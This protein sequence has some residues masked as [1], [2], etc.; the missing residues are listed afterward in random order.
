MSQRDRDIEQSVR[1]ALDR[2]VVLGIDCVPTHVTMKGRL[3]EYDTDGNPS[4][5]YCSIPS[6]VTTAL[7]E[8]VI[9]LYSEEES[10]AIAMDS[11]R[12][13][14]IA[15]QESAPPADLPEPRYQDACVHHAPAAWAGMVYRSDRTED[16]ESLD[17]AS[18]LSDA[19]CRRRTE[20]PGYLGCGE[21][22]KH[23]FNDTLG[24]TGARCVAVR[25]GHT[26]RVKPSARQKRTIR[27]L[28][29]LVLSGKA[30]PA[31]KLELGS[32]LREIALLR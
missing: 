13:R 3:T 5:S 27:R 29:P 21:G 4:V 18:H 9:E 23:G 25:A 19:G 6:P 8:T 28:L 17:S 15:R 16:K 24:A 32:V 22:A 12:E 11:E 14:A 2:L 7:V 31:M 1:W 26:F 30:T 10:I 20:S